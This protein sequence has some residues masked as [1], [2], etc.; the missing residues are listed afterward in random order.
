MH[1]KVGG[2]REPDAVQIDARFLF[3]CFVP[4]AS[5]HS[6]SN[7]LFSVL[8]RFASIIAFASGP[9]DDPGAH[10]PSDLRDPEALTWGIRAGV[11]HSHH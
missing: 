5:F 9:A 4:F 11:G 10:P 7:T 2:W 8:R 6:L 1:R 3:A